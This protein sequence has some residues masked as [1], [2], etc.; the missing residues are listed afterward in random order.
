MINTT[1]IRSLLITVRSKPSKKNVDKLAILVSELCNAY[2][3]EPGVL[4][5]I[6]KN[7]ESIETTFS[8][9]KSLQ[10]K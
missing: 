4:D 6:H 3:K 9:I 7:Q 2:D 1:E 5:I 8:F 10:G